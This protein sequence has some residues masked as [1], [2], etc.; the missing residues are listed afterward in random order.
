MAEPAI[1]PEEAEVHKKAKRKAKVLVEE[2][3]LY[4]KSKVAE[5]REK[6]DLYDRLKEDID[7]S[8]ASYH[9]RYGSTPAGSADYFTRELVRILADNDVTLLGAN[10]PG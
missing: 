10:F 1:P 8:R 7:K 2:I 5:G 6:R 3:S 4:N 9:K